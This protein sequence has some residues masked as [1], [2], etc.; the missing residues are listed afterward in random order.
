MGQQLEGLRGPQ[1]D[2]FKIEETKVCSNP[3]IHEWV[4]NVES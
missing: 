1:E 2:F 4:A 3:A